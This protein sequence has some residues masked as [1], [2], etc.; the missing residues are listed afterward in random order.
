MKKKERLILGII[1][2]VIAILS[3]LNIGKLFNNT[4]LELVIIIGGAIFLREVYVHERGV[5]RNMGLLVSSLVILLG[6]VPLL[7]DYRLL[8]FFSFMPILTIKK[9]FLELVVII[10]GGYL[11]FDSSI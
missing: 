1:L 7:I 10:F 4:F 6:L 2:V 3:M 11:I 9:I 5:I 8:S